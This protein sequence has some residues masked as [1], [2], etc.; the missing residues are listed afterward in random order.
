ML[1]YLK[2]N[3]CFAVNILRLDQERLSRHSRS[4]PPGFLRPETT[5]QLRPL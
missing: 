4:G 2:Q 3:R 5:G 1:D